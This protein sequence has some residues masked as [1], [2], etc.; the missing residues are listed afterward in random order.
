MGD[1]VTLAN[2]KAQYLPDLGTDYDAF[3][4]AAITRASRDIDRL[5]GSFFDL[6]AGIT[7]LFDGTD[8]GR[9][10]GYFPDPSSGLAD[11]LPSG[12]RFV[13]PRA[14]PLASVTTLRVKQTTNGSFVTVPAGDF[15]LEPSGRPTGHPARWIELSDIPT[16]GV[17]SFGRGKRTIE[18]TGD[19]GWT[20]TPEEI[21]EVAYELVV[22]AFKMRG[23]G[24]SDQGGVPGL[25]VEEVG[26][27]LSPRALAILMA[28]G[29]KNLEFA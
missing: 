28:H 4:T 27:S 10:Y 29:Y 9:M 12:R 3:L 5:T 15:F 26:R 6:K 24:Q 16:S 1:Y 8:A 23:A 25:D 18:I 21:Q 13:L 22:R 19:W 11:V 14:W 2:V 17:V 7:N 20:L